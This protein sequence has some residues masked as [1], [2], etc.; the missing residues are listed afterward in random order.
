MKRSPEAGVGRRSE[1]GYT[2]LEVLLVL[3]I[4]AAASAVAIP[5]LLTGLDAASRQALRMDLSAQMQVL[6]REA[7]TRGAPIV[8]AA[9]APMGPPIL[10]SPR[11]AEPLNAGAVARVRHA[12]F[13]LPAGVAIRADR[14]IEVLA[15]GTCLPSQV[16]LWR[17]TR[18]V[19]AFQVEPDACLIIA[20]R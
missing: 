11:G 20:Q 2:L 4:M 13:Q 10:T 18:L 8:I 3:A 19:G 14:P 6:R 9:D 17:G 12:S 16:E 15:D 1:A 5:G 7:F